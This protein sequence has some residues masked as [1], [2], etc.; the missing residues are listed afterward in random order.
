MRKYETARKAHA[1]HVSWTLLNITWHVVCY[2][3]CVTCNAIHISTVCVTWLCTRPEMKM[4]NTTSVTRLLTKREMKTTCLGRDVLFREFPTPHS[5][6]VCKLVSWCPGAQWTWMRCKQLLL[7]GC[8]L[9]N[10]GLLP[11]LYNARKTHMHVLLALR[12]GAPLARTFRESYA[13]NIMATGT[14]NNSNIMRYKVSQECR[15]FFETPCSTTLLD[16][17]ALP[18]SI[19]GTRKLAR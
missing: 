8:W 1:Q 15:L 6:A 17:N 19:T 5:Q 12:N 14:R 9:L 16:H 7:S 18:Y 10:F 13:N 11:T 2:I 4:C 3:T